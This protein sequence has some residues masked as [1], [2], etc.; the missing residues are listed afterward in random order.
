MF[1]CIE[2]VYAES[3]K[4]N[5]FMQLELFR[6]IQ[7]HQQTSFKNMVTWFR[8]MEKIKEQELSDDEK[9]VIEMADYLIVA[10]SLYDFVVDQLCCILVAVGAM[11]PFDPQNAG[12]CEGISEESLGTKR[13]FLR[14]M[15]LTQLADN[16]DNQ[17]RNAA[18]HQTFEIRNNGVYVH[19]R[20]RVIQPGPE[21]AK[22]RNATMVGYQAILHYY[23]LHHGPL[24]HFPDSVFTTPAGIEAMEAAVEKMRTADFSLWA[25]MA[26]NAISDLD[27]PQGN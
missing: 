22:L 10:E 9:Y 27:S 25:E 17:I 6:Q 15:G 16:F 8:A 18:G 7:K 21:Y 4:T 5:P 1:D 26:K 12:S 14:S 19:K 13:S 3:E 24:F 2:S 11:H 20:D 23:E